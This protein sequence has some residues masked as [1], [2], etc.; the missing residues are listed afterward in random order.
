[1]DAVGR[2]HTS[3]AGLG[4]G[5]EGKGKI[6]D[7]LC[8]DFDVVIRYNGGANA[9][10]T[11]CVADEK[12]AVHLV[13]S[14]VLHSGVTGVIGPGVVV[15]PIGLV[16][17]I[18]G[19]E[20]RGVRVRDNLKISDRAHAVMP[21]HKIEDALSEQ[22]AAAEKIGTTARGIGP[23]Y[24]DKMRRGGAIRIVDL[25]NPRKLRSMLEAN[26]RFK[27]T[28]LNAL[29][30][31]DGGLTFEQAWDDV[32]GAAERLAGYVVDTTTY[33]NDRLQAGAKLLFEGANGTLLDVDHGTYPYVTSSSTSPA[34]IAAG[35]GIPPNVVTQFMGVTKAYATRVGAGPF[36]T[37]LNDETGERIRVA[38]H[39][40]GTTT[41]RPRR[42]GWFD[43]VA[44]RYSVTLGGT[45]EVALMHLDTLSGFKQ[46][47]ICT[48]YRHADRLMYT[49]PADAEVLGKAE[50]VIELLP[51]WDGNLRGAKSFDELPDAAQAYI[52]RIEALVGVNVGIVS[53]G[54]ERTQ[55]LFRTHPAKGGRRA[56][57]EALRSSAHA[58]PR[59]VRSREARSPSD[60]TPPWQAGF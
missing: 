39:E 32:A 59:A 42:C 58:P 37:E 34:G 1:M 50:P 60:H 28:V 41:G 23:C 54:P 38:G 26:V 40:Y 11:V 3:V 36:P 17:E 4:W 56:P 14:G 22:A 30:G 10:H 35:A 25:L 43:A 6:V 18:D 45:T 51:G 9:G 21:Y 47:G 49:L 33:L 53:V 7:L 27:R 44:A 24:A 12:F 52:A 46:V 20:A 31:S 29:Y 15:D 5:D 13:P 57:A 48:A 19:L 55:T 8:P 16:S 2:E